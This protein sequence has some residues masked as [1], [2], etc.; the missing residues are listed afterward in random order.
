MKVHRSIQRATNSGRMIRL[1]VSQGPQ[2]DRVKG[3]ELMGCFMSEDSVESRLYQQ[4]TNRHLPMG[5]SGMSHLVIGLE[6]IVPPECAYSRQSILEPIV[7][8]YKHTQWWFNGL[9]M[10]YVI[11]P[12]AV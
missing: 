2:K 10:W 7:L 1:I 5:Q 4:L 11:T 3:G 12:L 6:T 8:V 9:R